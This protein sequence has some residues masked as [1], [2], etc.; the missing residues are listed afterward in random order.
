M[1][2]FDIDY[3]DYVIKN[4]LDTLLQINLDDYGNADRKI[5]PH[6]NYSVDPNVNDPYPVELDD[7]VRLH[8]LIRKYKVITALEIGAGKSTI[9]I[10]DA[11]NKNK[12]QY[13][14]IVKK[15]LRKH[16]SFELHS[17][18]TSSKWSELVL[19]G[20]PDKLNNITS[21]HLT[22]CKMSTFNDRICTYFEHI[23]DI[24]PDFIYLDGPD[25]YSP[26]GAVN[27][28]STRHPDRM[29]MV[30]DILRIEHFLL[31]GTIIMVDG[32][33]ANAR[34]MKKNF[35][36]KWEYNHDSNLDI[37]IFLNVENPLGPY[38]KKELEFKFGSK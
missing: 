1:I 14:D 20:L 24:C 6:Q 27:G 8:Y 9:V 16:N 37:H 11:L 33:T 28:F 12:E 35:Q 10:A 26:E 5:T 4:D 15:K 2:N 29:P 19:N 3:M 21:I 18:E 34:F 25:Q 32:R 7:L 31:P 22:S 30:A 17:I 36:L 13:G 23:P 38:N